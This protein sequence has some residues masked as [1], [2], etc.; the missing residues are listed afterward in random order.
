MIYPLETRLMNVAELT[1]PDGDALTISSDGA[2]T[3]ITCTS[4]GEE[5]TVGPF[6]TGALKAVLAEARLASAALRDAPAAV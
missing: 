5:V 3:W 4:D 1:D 6:P 2:G